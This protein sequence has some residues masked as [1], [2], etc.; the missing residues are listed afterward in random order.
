MST[1]PG[2][3]FSSGTDH[4]RQPDGSQLTRRD[5]RR[6]LSVPRSASLLNVPRGSTIVA[7]EFA[8]GDPQTWV[9]EGYQHVEADHMRLIVKIAPESV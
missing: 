5:P 3:H 2:V 7:A 4:E 6:V 9:V 1:L 8:G